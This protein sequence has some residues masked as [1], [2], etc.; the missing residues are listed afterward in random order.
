[1]AFENEEKPYLQP[2]P[3]S[4]YEMAV[5]STATIQPD[6]L[7]TVEKIKYSVPYEF[8]GHSVDIRTTTKTIEVFFHNNR[9]ASHIRRYGSS[10]PQILKEHMPDNHKRYLSWNRDTFLEWART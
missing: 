6:Y 5:W 9:I 8:I 4:P 1:M 7:I 3:A 2:L 10:D